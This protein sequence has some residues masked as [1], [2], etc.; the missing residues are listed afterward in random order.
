MDYFKNDSIVTFRITILLWH[1]SFID[2]TFNIIFIKK[3]IESYFVRFLSMINT[4]K[5]S[6]ICLVSHLTSLMICLKKK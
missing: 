2:L 4:K 3:K 1:V 5:I 6:I